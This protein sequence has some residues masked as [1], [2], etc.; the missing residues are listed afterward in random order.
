[1]TEP[2]LARPVSRSAIPWSRWP[3]AS[4]RA[5]RSGP[6]STPSC[7]AR[8]GAQLDDRVRQQP[9]LGRARGA[10]PERARARQRDRARTPRIAG[11]LRSA[12]RSRSCSKAG[13]LPCLV[14]TSSLELGIDM[15]AV[16]LVLQIE[17]PK[18]VARGL[19][20]IGRAGHGVGEVSRGRIFPKFRGDLLECAVVARRMHEG[21][22][23]STV[24]PRNALDVLAQQIVAIAVAGAPAGPQKSRRAASPRGASRSMSCTRSSPAPTPTPSSRA[25][26]SRTCSTC[27][28]G[29]TRRRSSASCAR[30]SS[31]I[32][33]PARSARARGSR[34]LA[35]ANAGTIPD[36]GLYTVT[37]PD[38]RRV[39]ELDE[40]MVYEARPGQAFLLGRLH[41]ADRGDRPRPRD[42]H[43]RARRA[44]RGAVLEGRLGRAP[45]GARRGDRRVL[46]LGRRAGP[47]RRSSATTTSTS[48]PRATCSTTCASSRR[49]RA[50]SRASARSCV[51]RF[52][53]EI[54]DWRLCV[55]SPYGGRVHA[56]WALALSARIRERF[57]L[58]S[59]AISS[60]D[61]IVLH[62]PDLDADDAE[63]RVAGRLDGRGG[64]DSRSGADRARRGRAGRHRRAGRLRAVRRALSRERRPG[65]ARSPAPTPADA[66]PL[67]QQRLKAQNLLEVAKRYA[68]FP[69]VLET[70]RE[71]LRDVLDVPGLEGLLR[72]LH[73]REISLV[74]VETP[75]A[76]PFASSLLFDYVATY[77]YE[78][79]TP[80]AERRA[81]ALSLD[82]DLLRELL[83]QE[84]LRELID[85]GALARVEDDLQHRS[86]I[87]RATGRDGLHDVLRRVGDLTAEEVCRARVRGD[88]LRWPCC[89]SS[90]ANGARSACA[91]AARS[92]TSRPTRPVCIATRSAPSRPAACRRPSSRTCPTRCACS[93]RA[94]RARTG[95]SR[96]RSCTR[97]TASTTR[98]VLR[99]LERAA[100]SAELVRGELRPGRQR[101]GVVRRGGPT[102]PRRASLAALRK[103]IEPADARALAAFLPSWQGVDRH[104]GRGRRE[105]TACAR[106]SCRLQGLALPAEIWERDVLPRRIGAYSPDVARQPLRERR[107]RVGRRGLARAKLRA[108][109]AVLPRGRA[110]D[111]AAIG[112]A[113]L[114]R[115]SDMLRR[116]PPSTSCCAR[117]SRRGPCFFTD[118][119]AELDARGRDAH[120][121]PSGTSCGRARRRTTLGRRCVRRT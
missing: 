2:E 107:G 27:S 45:E 64:L 28:T 81:A 11:T 101:A 61:G 79:D 19:Q 16:D 89:A 67:W 94:S 29:A 22:I 51:E 36:R 80:N 110:A 76:S 9:P 62:L 6:R 5:T 50:C 90:S 15:G 3:E 120:A 83:G 116:A 106:C 68:D 47:A 117:G 99:E 44:R 54:G 33:S 65:A 113:L 66:R 88:R 100:P 7:S 71:C 75:T 103:E 109:G 23:E 74:E 77:M 8:A 105:S 78:G 10:A 39:G 85:P 18:S 111:R 17:S 34:Q 84:E 26:C 46:A 73:S 25:S 115:A 72:G 42:R 112:A 40:E 92:A 20:R 55:L 86:E 96:P 93:S 97:A 41:L 69:I 108:R 32:A 63:L 52:R 53:D 57:D 37:L 121:R 56:A 48:A 98:A 31:G 35:I 4:P 82:R 21:L 119:L 95:R 87:T 49:P 1:M 38:G 58:E 114:R 104:S 43:P 59:D 118:L 91:S 60:D 30:A 70:Y 12:R 14:A 13:E 102:P 24:V